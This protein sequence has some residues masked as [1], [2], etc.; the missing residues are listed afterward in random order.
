MRPDSWQIIH[1]DIT[2]EEVPT[3][4]RGSHIMK[5]KG[6]QL[7]TRTQWESTAS[8]AEGGGAAACG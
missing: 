4:E 8:S 5:A 6:K 2:E 1:T 3:E 7:F